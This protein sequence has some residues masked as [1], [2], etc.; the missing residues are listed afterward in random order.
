MGRLSGAR[1]RWSR[2]IGIGVLLVAVGTAC[3]TAANEEAMLEARAMRRACPGCPQPVCVSHG[4]SPE[5][6]AAIGKVF[7][8]GVMLVESVSAIG[9]TSAVSVP[10][11]QVL[12]LGVGTGP[13]LKRLSDRVVGVDVW[14]GTEAHTYWF[15]WNGSDWLD[16]TPE[17]VEVTDTT[18]VT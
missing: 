5:L 17:E 16:V 9:G 11:C 12:G 10:G 4:T 14:R 3:S 6:V 13:A 8:G 1:R 2:L 15:R 7:P 18:A